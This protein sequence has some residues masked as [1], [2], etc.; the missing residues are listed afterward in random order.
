M[1]TLVLKLVLNGQVQTTKPID[2]VQFRTLVQCEA[3]K[4]RMNY[5]NSTNLRFTCTKVKSA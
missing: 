2:N 5:N 1:F 4:K 3:Y